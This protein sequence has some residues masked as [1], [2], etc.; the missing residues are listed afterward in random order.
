MT[1]RSNT[2]EF[3]AKARGV[4]G[5][6]YIYDGAEYTKSNKNIRIVCRVHGEFPQLP[7]NHLRGG[8]CLECGKLTTGDKLRLRTTD[9]VAKAVAVHGNTYDYSQV[10]YKL[11]SSNVT[12]VC[13]L[14]GE[15][16]QSPL[17][18]LM[19]KGCKGCKKITIGDSHRGDVGEF[20]LSAFRVHGDT[21]DYSEAEYI[22]SYTK[23]K[24][25]CKVH[26][27]FLQPPARHIFGGGCP[28]CAKTG[29]DT[30]KQGTL[31]MLT[32]GDITKVGITNLAAEVRASRVSGSY[33]KQFRIEQCWTFLDGCTANRLESELLAYLRAH[34]KQPTT[35]FDGYTECFF[36]VDRQDLLRR[37]SQSI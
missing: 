31:Y 2:E 6:M 25:I 14:H 23:L 4:H 11:T 10:D 35:K 27:E 12:I 30:A 29:Y 34:Y 8:G 9:F 36:D 13:K 19:G 18:H 22:D 15:F 28:S 16:Q 24:I 26:G 37:V 21:Y 1:K 3:V 17:N 5:D 7:N 33:G 32:C 20:K